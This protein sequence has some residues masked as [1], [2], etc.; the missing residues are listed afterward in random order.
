M[1]LSP[2]PGSAFLM[3]EYWTDV[4]CR[5]SPKRAPWTLYLKAEKV[6]KAALQLL[7]QRA[8]SVHFGICVVQS[9]QE[10][11]PMHLQDLADFH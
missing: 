10:R 4:S 7:V 8:K 1:L 3:Q 5:S 2:G 9:L 11:N 6:T